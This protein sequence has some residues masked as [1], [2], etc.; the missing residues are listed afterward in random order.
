MTVRTAELNDAT[1]IAEIY[2]H[3]VQS[4]I[5]T[6]EEQ[7]VADEEM[8]R[9]IA[10]VQAVPLTWLVAEDNGRIVG[11]SYATHWRPRSAYRFSAESTVYVKPGQ[12]RR[13]IGSLL[14]AEMLPLLRARGIHAV[15]GGIA[16]PNE[17]S[18]ALHEKIGFAK[19]AHFRE[20]GFKFRRWIDVGYW[21]LI[22]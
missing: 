18:I 21:Q 2:N 20:A 4:S 13:G 19:V 1:A 12:E 8:A 7:P 6:F 11:Y 10:D 16:L 9:R 5:I 3:Y 15:I 14:Y 22:L 17:A